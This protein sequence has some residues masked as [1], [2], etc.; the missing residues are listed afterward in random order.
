[1][2]LQCDEHVKDTFTC[3]RAQGK[4]VKSMLL[5]LGLF[6]VDSNIRGVNK[7]TVEVTGQKLSLS[8][9]VLC[10]L[11]LVGAPPEPLRLFPFMTI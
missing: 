7:G 6:S 11:L 2:S 4:V 1:M 10:L 5:F 3:Y 9:A 8:Q